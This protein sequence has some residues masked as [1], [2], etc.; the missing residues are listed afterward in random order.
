MRRAAAAIVIVLLCLAGLPT[1]AQAAFGINN[2]DV[3]FTNE[4]GTPAEAG[5]H[6]FA[7]TIAL[8]TNFDEESVPVI[9]EGWLRDIFVEQ[10]PGLAG[11]TTAYKPCSTA[12]FLEVN[13]HAEPSCSPSSQVG[14]I[15]VS[16]TEAGSWETNPVFNVTPPPGKL[17][18]LGFHVVTQNIYLDV[19]LSPNSPY[20]AIGASRNTLQILNFFGSKL[21]LW[22]DP[23]DPAHSELRGPCGHQTAA[24]EPGDIKGFEFKKTGESGCSVDANPRPFLTMPTDCSHP[25][26]TRY[27][28]I[29]WNDRNAD[30]LPDTDSGSVL[31]HDLFDNP[32]FLRGCGKLGPFHPSITAR[33]TSKAAHSPTG[34]D[35]SLDVDDPGLTSVTGTAQSDIKKTVV[36]LPEG[37]TVNPSQAEG[38]EVCS[39]ED[40]ARETLAS[41]PGEGCPE[42]SKI[43]TVEVESPLVE[44]AV[45]G[46]LFVAAPHANLAGDSLLAVYLVVKNP[47]LGVIVKQPL[48]IEPDPRTGQL[49]TV[50]ENIPQLPFSH[51]RLHFREGG[52][53]PLVTPLGCGTYQVKAEMTPWSGAAP[54]TSTAA[55]QIEPPCSQGATPPFEPG[56]EAGSENNAAGAYSPFSMHLTRRDGDQDLTRFDAT[57]PPGVVGKLAGLDKCSEAQIAQT[58]TKTGIAE[59][60]SPSCPPGSRIG[61][62]QAGAG[63][64]SQLT[65]VPG[66]LYLAGPFGGGPLSVVSVVP[67]VA[68]PFDIGTVVTRFALNVDPRTAKVSVDGAHSDPIPHILE[69]IPLLVR[70]IQAN[71]DRADFTINPTSCDPFATKAAIWGG[72]ADPFS[73]ADDSPVAREDRYQASNC[74][75]LGFKPRLSLKLKG[76][77]HRGDNPALR[78]VLKARNGDANI[79]TTI[80]RLPRSA[81]LDQSHIKTICTRVQ[82]AAS[83]CP[84]GSIYGDVRAFTPLLSEPLVGPIYLRSSNHNLPDLVF[85]L[86]GIVDF[87]AV[88]RIDSKNGGIRTSFT[89]VP[90]APISKVVVSMRGAKKGLIVNS[91]NLCA[92]T[93]RATIR[94]DAHNGKGVTIDPVMQ[95]RCSKRG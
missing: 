43:G 79:E 58:K 51:F 45:K 38:L 63:V 18:R 5:T 59:L 35:F 17:I 33:P 20:N 44:E 32:A 1:G 25:L 61:T 73:L 80:V 46:S 8:G 71:V 70:D 36:T 72:G 3:S 54:F 16:A 9:P 40:L 22:G 88:A 57:L 28:A 6:P 62:V 77:T 89:G 92:A 27:E 91:T 21:Q 60:Q 87:E 69:G 83:N 48:R 78:A 31:T 34:L 68:G 82:Y 29:S 26:T 30:G 42:A 76:G 55:F 86:H 12:K 24:L 41:E 93:H 52:R 47:K 39:E 7:M 75:R 95:A 81:F 11:D 23:S 14:I 94:L 49:I 50:A 65:Y 74:A 56:F 53:S 84:K 85:A 64:G 4:D 90:D 66:S 2:F 19:G 37:M 15:A 67:A 13:D 10:M